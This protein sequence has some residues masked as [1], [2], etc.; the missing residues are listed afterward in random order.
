MTCSNR[1]TRIFVLPMNLTSACFAVLV[2]IYLGG[3]RQRHPRVQRKSLRIM[4]VT[5]VMVV[6]MIVVLLYGL[7]ARRAFASFA[8]PQEFA[9]FPGGPRLARPHPIALY[10]RPDRHID[11][12]ATR[13]GHE[14]ARKTWRRSIARS[15]IQTAQPERTAFIIFPLLAWSHRRCLV[16][17][18]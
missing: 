13:A 2:T 11:R 7:G 15:S 1:R 5:T 14:P 8:A 3:E 6:V 4:Y 10:G 18:L 9:I 17:L 16:S 12:L